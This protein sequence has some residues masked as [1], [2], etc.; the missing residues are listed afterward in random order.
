MR[1][2]I[3]L[4]ANLLVLLVVGLADERYISMHKRL[5]AYTAADYD[6]LKT[7]IS[8]SAGVAV[9]PNVLSE[10]SNLL[11]QIADPAKSRIAAAFRNLIMKM[12]TDPKG[13]G[14]HEIYVRSAD[15][16]SRTEFLRLGLSDSVLLEINKNNVVV[17]SAD[18]NLY[19]AACAA[20]Y[21][22]VNFHHIRPLLS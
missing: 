14:L 10:A 6:L 8:E 15:A 13:G 2:T 5:Q 22:A 19:L 17:L 9:M 21:E 7:L 16:S 11:R 3:A 4:D 1:K 18:L 20:G 12:T